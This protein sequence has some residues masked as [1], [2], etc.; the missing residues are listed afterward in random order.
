MLGMPRRR[1]DGFLQVHAGMNVA[2]EEL[3]GPLVLL[4]AA[5][6]S[7]RQIWLAVAQCHGRT[8]RSARTLARRQRRW[9]IFLQ[10][11]HLG[12]AAE[13]EAKLRDHRRR[14]QPAAG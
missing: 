3:R 11:E 2:Q 10:P 5:G 1:V 12:A 8:E 7:P 4:I 13:T 6:R 14:L 9:M